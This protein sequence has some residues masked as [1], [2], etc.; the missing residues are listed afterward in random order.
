MKM[1]L[2]MK[3]W[4]FCWRITSSKSLY[5]ENKLLTSSLDHELHAEHDPVSL[6]AALRVAV[7]DEEQLEMLQT[8]PQRIW[9]VL[10]DENEK[11]ACQT[12]SQIIT[13]MV[14]N[15]SVEM[16]QV[17]SAVF[18]LIQHYIRTSLHILNVNAKWLQNKTQ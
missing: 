13:M 11:R 16:E 8:E 5:G 7:A 4:I 15:F 6:M 2:Q 9:S 14:E 17:D 12:F 10:S 1:S 3:S 18:P